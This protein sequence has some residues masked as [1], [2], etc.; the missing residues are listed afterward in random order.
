MKDLEAQ[1][2]SKD[3]MLTTALSEKRALEARLAELQ[4]QLQEVQLL[5]PGWTDV[6]SFHLPYSSLKM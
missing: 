6:F 4:E 5:S 2:N 3:A 1:L